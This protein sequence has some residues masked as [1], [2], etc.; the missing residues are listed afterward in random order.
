MVGR[1]YRLQRA[2]RSSY[3]PSS[4]LLC[5]TVA[6]AIL[7]CQEGA[8]ARAR[9]LVAT[10]VL[11]GSPLQVIESQMRAGEIQWFES[12]MLDSPLQLIGSPFGP[13]RFATLPNIQELR[14][15]RRSISLLPSMYQTPPGMLLTLPPYVLP[16]TNSYAVY[17]DEPTEEAITPP[18]PARPAAPPKFFSAR[19]GQFE[20]MVVPPGGY[21]TNEEN[22]PC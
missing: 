14:A 3:A 19:C 2:W 17:P 22:K 18:V 13:Y 9:D 7:N 21:L 16:F 11:M 20:E 15:T 6:S 10:P 1:R 5:I 12:Q 8:W 4:I